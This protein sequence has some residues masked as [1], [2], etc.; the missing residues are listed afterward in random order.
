[1]FTNYL[2]VFHEQS[3]HLLAEL[4]HALDYTILRE[5]LVI[6]NHNAYHFGELGILS[7]VMAEWPQQD[8]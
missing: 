5:I 6:A 4:D 2:G 1:M 3:K 7:Q 8:S